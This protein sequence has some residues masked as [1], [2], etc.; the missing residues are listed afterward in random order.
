MDSSDGIFSGTDAISAVSFYLCLVYV[1]HN[2][3]DA[4]ISFIAV[5]GGCS[6]DRP[7]IDQD[8]QL[9]STDLLDSTYVQDVREPAA[10]D[11]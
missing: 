7:E 9:T 10:D 3:V 11:R 6:A 2:L 4:W 5:P 8:R 1:V